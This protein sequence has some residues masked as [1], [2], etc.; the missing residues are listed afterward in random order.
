MS[1]GA[2]PTRFD[3]RACPARVWLRRARPRLIL[4]IVV[5]GLTAPGWAQ[6]ASLAS[7]AAD[8]PATAADQKAGNPQNSPSQQIAPPKADTLPQAP[9]PQSA[10]GSIS[11]VIVDPTGAVIPGA[12]VTLAPVAA[13]NASDAATHAL[14][15]TS[16]PD[17][18]FHFAGVVPGEF[19]LMASWPGFATQKTASGV[20]HPGENVEL[21][22]ITL[23][24]AATS[25]VQVTL[26]THEIA[27]YEIKAEEK[28]RVLGF[29]P[30]FYIVYAEHPVPLSPKQ[31]F[32]LAWR[33]NFDPVTFAVNGII[34]GYEQAADNFKEY[35]QGAAGYGKRYGAAYADGFTA[36]IIGSAILPSLLK[37]DPRYFYKGTGSIKSRALYAIA[38]AVICKGDNGRWQFNY[39]AVGGTLA[40]GGISNLYYP[41]ADRNGLGLTF[42][43]A[44][45]GTA[46]SA[47]ANLFQ[48]F[49]IRKLTPRV[50]NYSSP[51]PTPAP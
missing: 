28:Q 36:N 19:H 3:R 39:S 46:A 22:P 9:T 40:A 8:S 44:A 29:L 41:A 45:L 47:I 38:N 21:P 49:L 20:L 7:P 26:T 34:A 31:K 35:G 32:E 11:G 15:T 18:R 42:Q 24:L 13:A 12:K 16:G 5:G 14:E 48:E 51:A 33:T 27:E 4:C 1:V 2:A 43:N 30:N 25:D 37:Q 6:L 50:P 10:P 23:P 17:G